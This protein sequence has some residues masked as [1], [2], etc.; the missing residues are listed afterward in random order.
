MRENRRLGQN[1]RSL[2][3]QEH[4]FLRH[5]SLSEWIEHEIVLPYDMDVERLMQDMTVFDTS[6]VNIAD[7]PRALA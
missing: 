3:L 5:L 4:M 2:A 7:A 1:R 6:V